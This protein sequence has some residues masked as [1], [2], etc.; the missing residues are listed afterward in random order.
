MEKIKGL[1]KLNKTISAPLN[2]RFGIKKA[3]LATSYG[4]YPS[5]NTID[6]QI[7]TGI[8]DELFWRF[9]KKTFDF[10]VN[11]ENNFIFSLLHEVGHAKTNKKLSDDIID[12]CNEQKD[13]IRFKMAKA[14]TRRRVRELE[15]KYF[16]LP[17]EIAAT[18]WAVRYAKKHPIIVKRMGR[19][20]LKAIMTFYEMNGIFEED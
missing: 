6:F 2:K 13:K 4:Y 1:R 14:T 5:E 7:T 16:A 20:M 10:E 12:Y 9:V 15:Y 17:D 3:Q 8:E 19:E 11:E 18:A